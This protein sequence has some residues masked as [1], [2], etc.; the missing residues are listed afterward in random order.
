MTNNEIIFEAVRATFTPSQLADLV[1]ATYT[2]EQ[3]AA[4]RACVVVD[5]ADGNADDIITADLAADTFH[6]FAE[7]K[8][9]GFSVKKGQHAAIT[10]KLWK[11]T[12]KPGKAVRDAAAESGEDAPKTDPH[13]YMATAHLFNR[14]QVE[15]LKA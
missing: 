9:L 1:A 15:P 11:Y 3:I 10:C 13:F 12:D 7:W 6:T 14:L 2:P 8:K 4:R 5:A